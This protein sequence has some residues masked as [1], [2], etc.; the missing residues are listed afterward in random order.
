[1]FGPKSLKW[2]YEPNIDFLKILCPNV[3]FADIS[4]H[5]GPNYALV[6]KN[7]DK[8]GAGSKQMG[9]ALSLLE[10]LFS[11]KLLMA[12]KSGPP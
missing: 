3:F 11:I 12:E 5:G 10:A 8:V 9:I 1:M 2:R 4:P 6:M 7:I